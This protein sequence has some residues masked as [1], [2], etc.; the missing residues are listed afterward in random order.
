MALLLVVAVMKRRARGD[1][2]VDHNGALDAGL[3]GRWDW[4]KTPSGIGWIGVCLLLASAAVLSV[5]RAYSIFDPITNWALKGYAIAYEGSILAGA[6]WGG[7]GLA[8]PQNL[9][10]L[11]A[12]FRLAEGDVLPGSKLLDPLYALALGIVLY[13][14][15]RWS[16]VT[17]VVATLAV[18]FLLSTPIIFQHITYGYANFMFA[19]YLTLGVTQLVRALREADNRRAALGGLFVGLGA[20]TRPEGGLMGL[21][22]LLAL[23]V[24]SIRTRKRMATVFAAVLPFAG[25]WATWLSFGGKYQASDEVGSVL[26]QLIA[27]LPVEPP[28]WDV[29]RVFADYTMSRLVDPKVWGLLFPA[30][31]LMLALGLLARW[32]FGRALGPVQGGSISV[33]AI[34]AMVLCLGIIGLGFYHYESTNMLTDTFDRAF[35]PA[36]ILLWAWSVAGLGKPNAAATPGAPSPTT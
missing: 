6:R 16:G 19:T 14:F 33:A 27:Q 12:L 35:I 10:L 22:L 20:W 11:I 34:A 18:A 2:Q 21:G 24:Y 15:W 31:A 7:H 9:H 26:R 17:R 29:L 1:R 8:Y 28:K 25:V 3:A 5:G 30:V 13:E 36:G 23:G 32:R 4:W